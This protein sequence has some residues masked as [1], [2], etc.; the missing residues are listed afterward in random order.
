MLIGMGAAMG[1]SRGETAIHA[2][3]TTSIALKRLGNR[4]KN[5][6]HVACHKRLQ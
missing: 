6:T 4:A 5:K 2:R 3:I 1:E